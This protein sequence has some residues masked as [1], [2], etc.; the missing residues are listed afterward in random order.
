MINGSA[1]TASLATADVY[2]TKMSINTVSGFSIV[3]YDGN[4]TA[5]ATVPHGL[6]V[7][8]DMVVLKQKG[9][10]G[11]YFNVGSNAPSGWSAVV[12]WP[13][14]IAQYTNAGYFNNT[15]PNATV[16]TLGDFTDTNGTGMMAYC[17]HSVEGY[18]KVGSYTGNANSK[19]PFVYT[20][21]RPAFVMIKDIG[22][23]E[24]WQLMDDKRVGYNENNYQLFINLTSVEYESAPV[25]LVSNGFKLRVVE[26]GLSIDRAHLYYAV[27]ASPFK[28]S[29]AR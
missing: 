25:D 21:F 8:P 1:S 9:T 4:T 22:G 27:A 24:N 16:V 17:F 28:T 13:L 19:G 10:S 6:S 12:F 7:A 15:E 23:T 5:G 29:N 11:T 18:S 26:G 20:G 3:A 2:P 14:N